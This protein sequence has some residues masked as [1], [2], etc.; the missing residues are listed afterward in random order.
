VQDSSVE[1]G[2]E[3]SSA[4]VGWQLAVDAVG[5]GS[6]YYD[7]ASRRLRMDARM[8]DIL[9]VAPGEWRE[10]ID[11]FALRVHPEDR[12]RLRQCV[13]YSLDNVADYE[14]Q[15]RVLRP[16]GELRWVRAHGRAQA[17]PDGR[18][19]RL[20]G[21]VID[22]TEYREGESRTARILESMAAGFLS[23]DREWR[24]IYVNAET[25]RILG[26]PRQELVGRDLWETFSVAAEF[27]EAY[28]RAM[29]SGVAETVEAHSAA[30]LDGWYEVRVSPT[31]DGLSLYFIDVTD[32][33]EARELVRLSE[34][35]G[36]RLATSLEIEDAV[37]ELARLVVPAL[38]DWSIVSVIDADGELR[39]VAS[40]HHDPELLPVVQQ[41]ASNRLIDR[42]RR[43]PLQQAQHSSRPVVYHSGVMPRMRLNLTSPTALAAI[44]R[45][46]PESSAA[47]PLVA[48]GTV[49]GVLSICRG[50]QRPPMTA[51]EISVGV[52][53][54]HRAGLALDNARLYAE[55]RSSAE[56]LVQVNEQLRQ[57]V[58]HD[59][60]VARAL[61]DVML[62]RLP[63]PDHLHLVA[64]YLTASEGD[65]VGGDWYDAFVL[66]NGLTTLMIGDVVGHDIAAAALMGQLRNMLRALAWDRQESPAQTVGRLDLAMRDLNLETLATVTLMVIDQTEEDRLSGHR[67]LRWTNAGHPPPIVVTATG[68]VSVL[69]ARTNLMLGVDAIHPRTDHA[70]RVAPDSTLL[71]YTDGLI[72]TRTRDLDDGLERL[73]A[74]LRT[75]HH[76]APDQLLDSVVADMVGDQ[77]DDD[78]AVLAVR[79]N[80]PRRPRPVEAGPAHL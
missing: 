16:S 61:Q 10:S 19:D 66:P 55:Q 45:L 80:D 26:R 24:V 22:L 47:F 76:R 18:T 20:L 27:E 13:R 6:F 7:R 39:D 63:E 73:V 14:V 49:N 75:H 71:L 56:R 50:P 2:D 78:V 42:A 41:F 53:I 59:R 1:S 23:V 60:R 34:R 62:T 12:E 8:L 37:S 43:G 48:N 25:E 68:E 46:A 21:A 51:D 35:V 79:F 64:R 77:P 32:R 15:Y 29:K 52:G 30:P 4:R 65:Q 67:T 69:D 74:A 11:D 3:Y 5:I 72:E 28:R 54:A 31:V 17:G 70:C 40:W 44:E 38:G 36:Q 9:G 58:Q 57:M 33:H